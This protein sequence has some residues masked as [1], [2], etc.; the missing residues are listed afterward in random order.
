MRAD[1]FLDG[2]PHDDALVP[3]VAWLTPEGASMR[4]RDWANPERATLIAALYAQGDRVLVIFNRADASVRVAPPAPREGFEWRMAFDASDDAPVGAAVGESFEAPARAAL[5]L[6]EAKSAVSRPAAA[7]D[8]ALLA[9]LASACGIATHWRDVDGASHEVPRGTLERLVAGFGLSARNRNAAL[10]SL[11]TL[12]TLRDGRTLPQHHVAREDQASFV[13]F[14]APKGRAPARLILIDEEGRDAVVAP[15]ALAPMSWIG[16]DGRKNNGYRAQLPPLPAGRYELRDAEASDACTLL[17]APP[18]CHLDE[19]RR[20]VGFSA[21]LYAL[22]REGDQGVGDFTTLARL[23]R[24]SAEV[25]AALIAINPLHAL[26]PRDRSRASPYYPSDRRFVDPLYIDVADLLGARQDVAARRLGAQ[27]AV[28]Y[29]GVHALK[30]AALEQAF[31]RFDALARER[32]DAAPI[33]DFAQFIAEGGDALT[34]FALFEAISEARGGQNWRDWPAPLREGRSDALAAVALEHGERLRFH[35]FLQWVADRQFAQAA[36][37]A[38]DSGLSLGF[39]RDLAVG[40]APDGAES[41]SKADRLIEDFAIGAPPDPF[42]REGQNWGLPAPNPLAVEKDAGADFGALVRANMRHAGALRIDHVMGLARLFLV[43]HGESARSGAYVSYPLE[44]LLAQLA[45]ESRRAACI[46]VGEDLGTLPWGFRE[47]LDAAN[48]LSY[49]VLWFERAD[50][51]FLPAKDYPVKAMACVST[52]DLPTLAGW[53]QGVDI[54]EK[55]VLGLL[56]VEAAAAERTAR[57]NDKAALLDALR[58]RRLIGAG[59]ADADFNDGLAEALHAFLAGA[60][61]VLAMA[62][63]DDLAGESVAV[64]LPGTDR[65][66]PNWRRKLRVPVDELFNSSRAAAVLAGLR[67]I[68]V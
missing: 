63:L 65:E 55:A 6:V 13:R 10:E 2:A 29:A 16:A 21:Q 57:W 22:R 38:Q 8:D 44:A 41:W 19:T 18:R 49:R 3:D 43:P 45:L 54:E 42:S 1:R 26:F 60:P 47:Q 32:P 40:A 20:D 61:C 68:L 53:W 27:D 35:R 34:R 67:R 56:S 11:A 59:R 39:C 25:G 9:R 52:H 12:A 51:R 66:R 4:E 36:R 28:D 14:A 24:K 64:N 17:V 48:V 5:L 30:S 58:A 46:V 15:T 62:Q 7:A 37:D 33:A 23:A 31:A 50:G